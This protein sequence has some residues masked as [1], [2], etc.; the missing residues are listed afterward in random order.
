M[1]YM[2]SNCNCL[3]EINLEK[4]DTKNVQDMAYNLSHAIL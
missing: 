2:F 3:L 4:F 1:S